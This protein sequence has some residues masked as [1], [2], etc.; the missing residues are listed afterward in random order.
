MIEGRPRP[1]DRCLETGGRLDALTAVKAQHCIGLD[2][3]E[4]TLRTQA[5]NIFIKAEVWVTISLLVE[6]L[7]NK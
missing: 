6:G 4:L 3:L 5:T 2:L 1:K 7:A